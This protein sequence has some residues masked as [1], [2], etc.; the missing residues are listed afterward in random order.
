MKAAA[1]S[2]L[3]HYQLTAEAVTECQ[4]HQWGYSC[5]VSEHI[6]LQ[7][8]IANTIAAWL[9]FSENLISVQESFCHGQMTGFVHASLV[10]HHEWF[11]SDGFSSSPSSI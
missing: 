8:L 3:A 2:P 6:V 1:H 11:Y 5:I 4:C 9:L 7:P 10:Q